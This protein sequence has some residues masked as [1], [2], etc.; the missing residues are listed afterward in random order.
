MSEICYKL[1]ILDD[2]IWDFFQTIQ[3][4]ILVLSLE[5]GLQD[6]LKNISAIFLDSY[7]NICLQQVQKSS[8][9]NRAL[10]V[11]RW[12]NATD[13]WLDVYSTLCNDRHMCHLNG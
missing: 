8:V 12:S 13:C 3:L 5:R 1:C 2:T 10:T 9:L 6:S 7:H 11:S 4:S